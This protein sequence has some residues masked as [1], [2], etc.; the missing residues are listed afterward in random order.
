[1]KRFVK[2]ISVV[3]LL[4]LCA[5]ALTSC[6]YS[7]ERVQTIIETVESF[8]QKGDFIILSYHYVAI[9]EKTIKRKEIKYEKTVREFVACDENG[10]Y[11]YAFD[12]EDKQKVDI[13]YLPYD[14]ETLEAQ[15]IK[16]VNV[17][18][19]VTDVK[20]WEG[21]FYLRSKRF[22]GSGIDQVYT[23][24]DKNT[25][26]VS[27]KSTEHL[28]EEEENG[29]FA[30]NTSRS[31]NYAFIDLSPNDPFKY[32]IKIQHKKTGEERIIDESFIERCE[33]GK[34]L[35]KLLR[36]LDINIMPDFCEKDG[37]IYTVF[38]CNTDGFL[39]YPCHHIILKYD[40]ENDTVE[41]YGSVMYED[42]PE[43]ILQL[44][45]Q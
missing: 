18:D 44:I 32:K 30:S 12:Q 2:L 25:D 35:S 38:Y 19:T 20:Y 40:F 29:L 3:L 45:I 43:W 9:N 36:D 8:E 42:Y 27:V 23:V 37:Y 17:P 13:I 15:F 7:A 24:Y 11:A 10:V 6:S 26:E 1:M 31:E 33:E 39:G 21:K 14:S 16:T 34:A 28:S 41:Y 5:T 22:E 4:T